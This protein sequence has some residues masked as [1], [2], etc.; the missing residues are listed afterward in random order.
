MSAPSV[1][2]PSNAK[3]ADDKITSNIFSSNSIMLKIHRQE[4]KHGRSHYEPSHLDP[5]CLQIQLLL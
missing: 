1:V 4:G 2:V 3:K 5:Q